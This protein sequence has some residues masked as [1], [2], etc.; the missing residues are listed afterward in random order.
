[1]RSVSEQLI[2][3]ISLQSTG[4]TYLTRH[5]ARLC[6]LTAL[7]SPFPLRVVSFLWHFP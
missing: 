3:Q 4:F 7:V 6:A 5:R 1:M 2:G